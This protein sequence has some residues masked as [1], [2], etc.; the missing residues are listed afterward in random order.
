MALTKAQLEAFIA[1]INKADELGMDVQRD[2]N[3][4][5]VIFTGIQ[6]VPDEKTNSDGLYTY[7]EYVPKE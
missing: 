3:G 7:K 6:R 1:L 5:F 4:Q 2:N